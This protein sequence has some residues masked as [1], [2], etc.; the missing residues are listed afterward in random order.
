MEFPSVGGVGPS[1]VHPVM[2]EVPLDA[3]SEKPAEEEAEPKGDSGAPC[4]R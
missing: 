3:P 2:E 4:L 1:N